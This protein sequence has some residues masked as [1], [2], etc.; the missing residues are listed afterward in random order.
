MLDEL[1]LPGMSNG[2]GRVVKGSLLLSLNLLAFL[3]HTVLD[4]VNEQYRVIRQILGARQ[5]FFQDLGALLRY[6]QFESWDALLSFM[7]EGL[8]LDT[9]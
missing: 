3:F 4:L 1:K 2:C 9:G 5:R 8:E 7:L 6:F